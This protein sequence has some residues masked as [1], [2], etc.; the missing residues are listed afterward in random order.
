MEQIE[1]DEKGKDILSLDKQYFKTY[2][3]FVNNKPLVDL[4]QC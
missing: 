4:K 3:E 2:K 1:M